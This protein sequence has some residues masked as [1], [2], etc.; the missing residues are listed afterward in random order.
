[1]PAL[2][3]SAQSTPSAPTTTLTSLNCIAPTNTSEEFVSSR[4]LGIMPL[5]DSFKTEKPLPNH[6]HRSKATI[7]PGKDE[8]E[9]YWKLLVGPVLKRGDD[10]PNGR[11]LADYINA[12][13]I[14]DPLLLLFDY[15]Q[16]V[17]TLAL[18]G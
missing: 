8:D 4:A 7:L 14:F 6:H 2:A 5:G 9:K 11:N 12:T 16:T 10:L 3:G 15:E 18:V 1:M 13:G 17:P